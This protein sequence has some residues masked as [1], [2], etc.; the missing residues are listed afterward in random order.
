MIIVFD[1]FRD[2]SLG[3][4][5]SCPLRRKLLGSS[6]MRHVFLVR[7]GQ[8]I[9]PLCRI[10]LLCDAAGLAY[11]VGLC[12]PELTRFGWGKDPQKDVTS[13][14]ALL[15]IYSGGICFPRLMD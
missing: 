6:Y 3:H 8:L 13:E 7:K 5:G 14:G 11:V 9:L 2:L 15:V 4:T 12:G 1:H 10:Q